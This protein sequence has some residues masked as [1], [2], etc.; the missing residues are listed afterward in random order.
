MISRVLSVAGAAVALLVGIY[1]VRVFFNAL[2]FFRPPRV[3]LTEDDRRTARARLP[4]IEEVTFRAEDGI[5]LRGFC[6]PSRN[7]AM[8]IM[9]HG[10]GENRMRFL[11]VAEILARH[12]YG[13]LFFDWRAHGDS[14]GST[15]T[16]SDHEQRDFAAAVEFASHRPDVVQGRIAGLGFSVGASTVAVEAARDPRVRAVI[17]EAVYTSFED[18]MRDKMGKRGA[19]SLWP[20]RVAARY[21]GVDYERIRPIDH[22]A[23]IGPRPLLFIA[24][25][26]DRD[27]AVAVVE[28]VFAAATEP[29]QMW[30]VEGAEHGEYRAVAPAE[31]ERTLVGFLDRAFFS[32]GS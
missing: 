5:G 18:E 1:E 22:I 20:T 15:S 6:V 30:I 27:T 17:L 29:K 4:D 13:S 19:L 10:L 2:A 7:G 3:P 31:Y 12:G 26:R 25:T 8:V 24:G 9:G 16:W 32:G 28:R 21:A 11:P 23:Q 14:D